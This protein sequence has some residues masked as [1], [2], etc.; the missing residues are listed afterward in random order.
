LDLFDDLS[1]SSVHN[2]VD[3]SNSGLRALDLDK[4]DWFHKSGLSSQLSGIEDTS[5]S[6]DDLTSSSVDGISVE[7]NVH[8]VESDSSHVLVGENSFLGNPLKSSNHRV[9]DFSEVLDSLG[10]VYENVGSI[11]VGTERPDL[12]GV[13]DIPSELVGEL[14]GSE[15]RIV[16][17]GDFSVVDGL[18]ELLFQ[19]LGND[20]ES[21]VLVW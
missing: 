3:T 21:V 7:N 19:R 17:R 11:S 20:E 5:G 14:T 9:L 16:L 10:D 12:S 15:L 18:G 1:S 8:K 13:G 4:E 2:S 6:G